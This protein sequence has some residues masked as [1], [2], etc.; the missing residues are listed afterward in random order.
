MKRLGLPVRFGI[1]QRVL[2]LG[3]LPVILITLV[4]SGYMIKTRLEH[5]RES[6]FENSQAL[7][8]Y[9]A[10]GSEF[11]L[12]TGDTRDLES[13]TRGLNERP[14]LTEVL[15]VND[16]LELVHRTGPQPYDYLPAEHRHQLQ[17]P[18]HQLAS[19]LWAFHAP[20]L[21]SDMAINDFAQTANTQRRLGWVV[22]LVNDDALKARQAEILLDG[23][24]ITLAGL[25]LTLLLSRSIGLSITRPL[26][27]LVQ[28]VNRLG[29][30]ELKARA[31][32]GSAGE[33]GEL[34]R[35][36]NSLAD[37]VEHN[38]SLLRVE[39][40]E[41]TRALR[42]TLGQL[43]DK[44]RALEEARARAET[45]NR[46]KGEFLARMSHEL[47][48]PLTSVLGFGQLLQ[49]TR[50]DHEQTEYSEIIQR[51]SG[52]LLALIDDVLDF[53]KLQANA[54]VLEQVPFSLAQAAED[55]L[56]MHRPLAAEKG[57][58]L[59]WRAPAGL[60]SQ[61]V[62][63]PM[64]IRQVMTN[65]VSNAVKFTEAGTV[66]MLLVSQRAAS[67]IN[68][69][70]QV[71]D[72]GPGIPSAQQ[73]RLFAPFAQADMSISRRYGG[74]GLGLIITKRLVEL[75]GGQVGL[76]SSPGVGTRIWARLPLA[77]IDSFP[78]PLPEQ[79][80]D[81]PD[82]GPVLAGLHIL[83]VE[84]NRFNRVLLQRMLEYRKAEVTLAENGR[85]A[86]DQVANRSF[87]L[88]LMDLHMP[89]M[90]GLEATRRIR[91][92]P[93]P[94]ARVPIIALTADVMAGSE[95]SFSR[96]GIDGI[97]YKPIDEVRLIE[98]IRQRVN[99]SA[100]TVPSGGAASGPPR[101]ESYGITP[102]ALHEELQ[103]QVEGIHRGFV[104]RNA[105]AM[106]DHAHQLSGLAGLL[107][108]A[109]LEAATRSFHLAA[110]GASARRQWRELW[111]LERVID[112]LAR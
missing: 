98:C 103:R 87:D 25:A 108:M 18:F 13:L 101:L 107:G 1:H 99:P 70:L 27:N 111:R 58:D 5:E 52:L 82:P 7:A 39:V 16:Q 53:S 45:A 48:T 54:I 79:V 19:G 12:F 31:R 42:D 75:M 65:L 100:T 41:A 61:V 90:D 89:D 86:L 37:R 32:E 15:F 59:T 109:E 38:Q 23:I 51:T 91:A 72:T 24:I 47:R 84:D 36:I 10:A 30:D 102:Q 40:D 21:A 96:S 44:N 85:Q 78:G 69:E 66:E 104:A 94:S 50:L 76:D 57:L 77:T 62:G 8:H 2:L 88:V 33:L 92:L 106:R 20:V 71:K 112:G 43:E 34:Q 64:R 105:E 97:L 63:D 29:A 60:P 73:A 81:T 55:I 67:G 11:A 28:T 14:E 4:L 26:E 35:G 3:L 68:L 6:L 95:E 74:S 93:A 110:K 9:L 46:A 83:V 80:G 56:A 49:R 17:Q 22:V